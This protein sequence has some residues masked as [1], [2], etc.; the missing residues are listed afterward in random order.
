M[1]F[2]PN[3][4]LQRADRDRAARARNEEKQKRRDEKA[5]ERRAKREGAAVISTPALPRAQ[6]GVGPSRA[7]KPGRRSRQ[8]CQYGNEGQQVALAL[9]ESPALTGV[10]PNSRV[11]LGTAL[12]SRMAFIPQEPRRLAL[13]ADANQSRQSRDE[14]LRDRDHGI[15]LHDSALT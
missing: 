1:A 9:D 3:Y 13:Q 2:K 10:A 14:P 5:A 15:L 6:R 8:S 11:M 12:V 7:G 4:N